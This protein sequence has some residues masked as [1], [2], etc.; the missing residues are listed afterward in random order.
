MSFGMDQSWDEGEDPGDGVMLQSLGG[1]RIGL[2]F[3]L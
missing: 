2:T 1:G 3:Y